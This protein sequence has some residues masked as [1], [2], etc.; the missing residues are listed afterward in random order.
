MN[1]KDM[2]SLLPYHIAGCPDFVVE[3][4]IKDTTLSFC[5][6]SD[7][8][9]VT[10]D[11]IETLVGVFEYDIDLPSNT[12]VVDIHSATLGEKEITP[13]TEKGA[14]HGNP[15]WRTAQGTPKSYIRPGNKKIL[16]VPVPM[17]S[18]DSV[19]LYVSLKPSLTAVGIDTDFVENYVDGI[20]AGTLANLFN[21][22]DMPWANPQRAMKHEAEFEAHIR[23]AKNKADGRNGPTR[24]TVRYGG[25]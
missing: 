9:R 19:T 17:T 23:D 22:H 24:R 10:L 12:N 18:G 1:Y 11:P 15:L 25:I 13:E 7:A 4:A 8:Y 2:V 3:K 6:R 14:T 21:A 5:R 16:L 20:M